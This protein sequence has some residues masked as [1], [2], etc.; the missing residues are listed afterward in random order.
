MSSNRSFKCQLLVA[1]A[2]A[3]L[4]SV[5][6]AAAETS[7][8]DALRSRPPGDEVI[9]FLLPDRFENGDKSNDRGH[10]KGDRLHTGFDPTSRAFYNGG[11]FKGVMQHLD[12][13][14]S[15]GAT[16]V[17]LAPVF[18]NKPV[19]G[20]P[21][22]ESSGYHGYWITDF[23]HVDPHFGTDAEF[24]KLVDAVHARG[25]KFYMDIVVNHTADV[26]KNKE[27][28]KQMECPYRSPAD[29]P[30]T[31]QGGV[32]GAPIN[33]GFLGDG[34]Q[35]EANFSRL[36]NPNY[37]YTVTVPK[38]EEHI[39]GPDWLNNPLY[40]HNR[41]NTTFDGESATRGDFVGLDD[42]MTENPRVVKG[43]I[44][45]FGTWIDNYGIDGFR[46][47]TARFVNPEFM[48]AFVPAMLARA[49]AKGI[50]NFHIFG[51]NISGVVDAQA[52]QALHTRIDKQPS[53]LDF[54]FAVAVQ[55]TLAG[56]AGTITLARL[57]EDDPLYEGG[58]KT[59]LTLPT[60]ISNH[61]AGR[62]GW[63]VRNAFP[64]ASDEEVL[65]RVVLA[66][67][68]LFTLRGVPTVYYGDE[69]GFAG[70]GGDQ[71]A[72]ADMFASKVKEYND[73]PLIGTKSTTAV[74]NFNPDHP[75]YH[76]IQ[77]LARL[78]ASNAALRSGRQ[79]VRNYS[80]KPGLFAVSRLDPVNG[81]EFVIAFNTSTS[82]I[83]AQVE[84]G[85][86]TSSFKALHGVCAAKPDAPGSYHVSLKALDY[87]VCAATP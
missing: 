16:A 48:A 19:Q 72:R 55:Q 69:Q 39:K 40:Y 1:A 12:Y 29:Y 21:G 24:K 32:H 37:A 85:H 87:V 83:E 67:A 71:A 73:T 10:L 62:F 45:I 47:D 77:E 18:K 14:Q 79:I 23:T 51:E 15:L 60:F 78:R 35:S 52:L 6:P 20:D 41:G 64:K 61:D 46:I 28:P 59:A 25:M 22:N 58:E 68:M 31:R 38:G 2:M 54:A 49:K 36:T 75:L 74:A 63:Y 57:F 80:E 4:S 27:C 76:A 44:E 43:M 30:Y 84:V 9:Y 11:D 42:I 81:R 13:I 53:V 17:W 82:P 50:P 86:A 66:H 56:N 34:V 3:M 7:T 26:I 65:K 33:D 70:L 5:Y 8:L